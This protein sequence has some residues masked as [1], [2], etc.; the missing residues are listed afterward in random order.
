MA[1]NSKDKA[2]KPQDVAFAVGSV[3]RWRV[4]TELAKGEPLPVSEIARRTGFSPNA[5]S[6][7]LIRLLKAGLVDC[8]YGLYRL[9][10][11]L[12][13]P[14]EAAIDFGRIVLRLEQPQP[15]SKG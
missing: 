12:I 8:P 3:R 7:I 11:Q 14:G 6:K 2:I 9:P 4:F 13:A 5:A 1:S 10:D 15:G